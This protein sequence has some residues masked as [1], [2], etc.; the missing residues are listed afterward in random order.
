M[1]EVPTYKLITASVISE[2]LKIRCSLAR[3]A[4]TTLLDKQLIKPV[5]E[6][7]RQGIYTRATAGDD[8]KAE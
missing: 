3:R 7:A 6:H 2:R 8:E 1:K 5:V 4:I